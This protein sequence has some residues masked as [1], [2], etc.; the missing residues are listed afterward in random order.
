MVPESHSY[1]YEKQIFF[2]LIR[3]IPRV[4]WEGKPINPGFDLGD[5]LGESGLSLSSSVIGE[6][7]LSFGFIAVLIG[8]LIFG[9]LAGMFSELLLPLP[10]SAQT[11]VYSLAAM[12]LVAGVRSL[13]ELVLMSYMLLAWIIVGNA[14]LVYRIRRM[15]SGLWDTPKARRIHMGGR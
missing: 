2:I 9:R 11:L 7:Y 3:P 8:G 6:L 1:V 5:I 12:T 4:F 14:T 10:G 15:L 13:L